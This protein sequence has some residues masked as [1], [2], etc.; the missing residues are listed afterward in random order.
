[1]TSRQNVA[2]LI[3]GTGYERVGVFE[4]F[5]AEVLR[6]WTDA[7]RF[8]EVTDDSGKKTP[9]DIFNHFDLDM[10]LIWSP[11]DH[12]PLKGFTE[13][14]EETDEWVASRNGAGAVLKLWKRKTSTPEHIDFRMIGRD[15]WDRDYRH[16]LVDLD[17]ERIDARAAGRG[18]EKGEQRKQWVFYGDLFVWEVMR[19]SM[20]D[21]CMYESLL[22]DPEW[23]LDFNRVYTDF[24]KAHYSAL[25]EL[26]PKPDGIWI[27]EDLG[28]RNGLFCSLDVLEK[29]IL[30]FYQEIVDFFH[31]YDL[32]VILHSCGGIEAALPLIIESGFDGLNPM[33]VKAGCD[34]YKFTEAYGDRLI[35]VG[36]LDVRIIETGDRDLIKRETTDLINGMKDRGARFLFGSDHSI[37]TG[38]TYD[39]YQYMLDV[40]RDTMWY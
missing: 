15:I 1:M 40:Y 17:L 33:E 30:P 11:I 18:I 4:H 31:G 10:R 29:L 32:P 3:S 14:V 16:Y 13:V 34:I 38:V 39:D 8:P 25:F 6:N 7:D 26:Q 12:F 36:G 9:G 27:Y 20:G 35:F 24:Y 37:T 2:G 22:L 28:Y 19:Q 21:F 23:I 5:W